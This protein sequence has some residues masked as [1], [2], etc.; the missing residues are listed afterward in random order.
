MRLIERKMLQA[1]YSKTDWKCDNTEVVVT[2]FAHADKPIERINVYL[3]G[4]NIATITPDHVE[5]CDC[6]Y[7]TT[8]TKSRLN[9]ILRELCGAGIY[10]KQHVWYATAEGKADWEI[11]KGSKHL[12][13]RGEN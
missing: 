6:K 13:Y 11:E 2:Y 8:T 10:Q 7:Q 4:S 3:H 1:I 5:I 9:T 12:F